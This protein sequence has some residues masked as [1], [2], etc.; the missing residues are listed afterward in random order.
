MLRSFTHRFAAMA[1]VVLAAGIG[2]SSEHDAAM[3]VQAW[4]RATPPGAT[5]GGVYLTIDNPGASDRLLRV[6]TPA[7]ERA[8]IHE[9][10]VV[11]G[12]MRMREVDG[13]QI[14]AGGEVKFEPGG[15]HLMLVGLKQPLKEG[16]FVPLTLEFGRAGTLQ[17]QAR[18]EQLGAIAPSGSPSDHP[19][20]D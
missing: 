10:S 18:V 13:L 16:E 19:S 14:P 12:Q 9:T 3:Q 20:H 5:V 7:S 6:R 4:A 2:C 11:D 8:E 1:A 15:L 17:V